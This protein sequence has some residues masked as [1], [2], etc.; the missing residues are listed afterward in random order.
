MDDVQAGTYV[1]LVRL[2]RSDTQKWSSRMAKGQLSLLSTIGGQ[3]L[4]QK[5]VHAVL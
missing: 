2:D 1:L 5:I 3:K 4:P